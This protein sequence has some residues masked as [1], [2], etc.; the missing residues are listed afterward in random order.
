MKHM[1]K[2]FLIGGGAV[3]LLLCIVFGAL[4]ARPLLASATG[5]S[6]S[7]QATA[8]PAAASKTGAYCQQWL[9]DLANRLHVSVATLRQDSNA[10]LSDVL[11]QMVKDGKLT[12][13]EAT[14]IKQRLTTHP[15]CSAVLKGATRLAIR[16]QLKPYL[17]DLENQ[18][19][20]GLHLSADQLKAQLQAGKTLKQI[21]DA[22]HISASQLHT[23]VLNAIEHELDRAAQAGTITQQQASAIKQYLQKHPALITRLVN[24]HFK[25]GTL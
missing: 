15:G 20:Q 13:S 7:P 6:G 18:I 25:S 11:D 23:I 2:A 16:Q 24:R 19:A 8:T 17:P 9:K 4:F 22:Q 21:A 1:K 12:Q 14:A 5:Q 10:A 3:L